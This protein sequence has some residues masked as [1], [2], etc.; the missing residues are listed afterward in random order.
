MSNITIH[1]LEP[2]LAQ[3]LEQRAIEHGHSVE[4]EIKDILQ[5]VLAAEA[6]N[7]PNLAE[8]IEK[9]FAGLGDFDLPEITREPMRT[10]PNFESSEA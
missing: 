5:R 7:Q 3:R 6:V 4:A 9:H 8:A 2:D 1:Q 10:V